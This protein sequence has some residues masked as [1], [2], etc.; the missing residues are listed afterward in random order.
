[1][2]DFPL[3]NWISFENPL[4]ITVGYFFPIMIVFLK[5]FW[6]S[7]HFIGVVF[8]PNLQNM[9]PIKPK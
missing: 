2:V 3:E 9:G 7:E 1:M 5:Y 8:F 4:L 6:N